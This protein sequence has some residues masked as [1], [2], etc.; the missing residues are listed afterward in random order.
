MSDLFLII[1]KDFNIELL[2][3]FFENLKLT[4]SCKNGVVNFLDLDISFG[5]ILCKI[6]TSLLN[7]LN[8]FLFN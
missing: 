3:E 5:Y 2:Y 6:K 7:L 1:H 8:L 4:I